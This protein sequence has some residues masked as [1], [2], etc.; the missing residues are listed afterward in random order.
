M[1]NP[2]CRVLRVGILGTNSYAVVVAI[3]LF[4]DNFSYSKVASTRAER[5]GYLMV[6]DPLKS[7]IMGS[8]QSSEHTNF[9]TEPPTSQWFFLSAQSLD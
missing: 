1:N 4:R 8:F 9:P 6:S 5:A 7:T 2:F 3:E